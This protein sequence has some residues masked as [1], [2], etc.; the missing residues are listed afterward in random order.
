MRRSTG[1]RSC[2]A[3]SETIGARLANLSYVSIKFMK[4]RT[5]GSDG[6]GDAGVANL[7]LTQLRPGQKMDLRVHI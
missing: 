4:L 1:C 7:C 5:E 2:T 6:H 3:V